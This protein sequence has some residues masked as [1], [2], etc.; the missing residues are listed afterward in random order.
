M[1]TID[2]HTLMLYF[3]Q[4]RSLLVN[5][6]IKSILAFDK[7]LHRNY[8]ISNRCL[9]FYKL[10]LWYQCFILTTMILC[11]RQKFLRGQTTASTRISAAQSGQTNLRLRQVQRLTIVPHSSGALA[12]VVGMPFAVLAVPPFRWPVSGFSAARWCWGSRGIR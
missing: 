12:V 6:E 7:L 5:H 2:N 10:C 8:A 4:Y 9:F 3:F 1:T 11:F